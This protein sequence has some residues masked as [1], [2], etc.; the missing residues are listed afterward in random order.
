M[1]HLFFI[2]TLVAILHIRDFVVALIEDENARYEA[3]QT[4]I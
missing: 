4:E 3:D 1:E 2:A